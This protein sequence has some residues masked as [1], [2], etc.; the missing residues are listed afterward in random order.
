MKKKLIKLLLPLSM[1]IVLGGCGTNNNQAKEVPSSV[2]SAN[3]EATNEDQSKSSQE[4]SEPVITE[5]AEYIKAYPS[6]TPDYSFTET[7]SY[8]S[9]GEYETT[10]DYALYIENENHAIL[11]VTTTYS[12][13]INNVYTYIG[14]VQIA[15]DEVTFSYIPT[16][17]NAM[18]YYVFALN[19][20]E[21]TNVNYQYIG[22]YSLAD[23]EGIYQI[24]DGKYGDI[25]IMIDR[26]A[27]ATVTVSDDVYSGY[28]YI[29][30]DNCHLYAYSDTAYCSIDW[31][32]YID[33]NSFSYDEAPS[34]YYAAY[35]GSYDCFGM[36]GDIVIEIDNEGSAFSSFEIDG[37]M[38]DFN[39]QMYFGEDYNDAKEE[40]TIYVT[41]TSDDGTYSL[42]LMLMDITGD[43][44]WNYSGSI[45]SP[46]SAG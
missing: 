18:A 30:D 26:F 4:E 42:D 44:T 29:E 2:E 15:D 28:I 17:D 33:G 35:A 23:Y 3:D 5:S 38:I 45:T 36:L 10:D 1:I 9:N 43:G 24:S 21:V 40:P 22:D 46:L 27:N 7:F 13:Y 37:S 14:N 31:I 11:T 32:I 41:L 25:S 6:S 12:E 19:N 20:G 8:E 16:S 34:S 39:G